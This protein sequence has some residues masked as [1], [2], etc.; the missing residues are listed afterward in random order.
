MQISFETF[1]L[2][3]NDLMSTRG[4]LQIFHIFDEALIG[5]GHLFR[6]SYFLE[7]RL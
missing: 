7:G 4:A 2:T 3:V 6:K 1:E 5:E